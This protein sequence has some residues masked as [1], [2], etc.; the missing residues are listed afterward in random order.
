MEGE[1]VSRLRSICFRRLALGNGNSRSSSGC[2][3]KRTESLVS[4]ELPSL[5]ILSGSTGIASGK[6]TDLPKPLR[7]ATELALLTKSS[8]GDIIAMDEGG[9]GVRKLNRSR[10]K[11]FSSPCGWAAGFRIFTRGK[12]HHV[13]IGEDG[14]AFVNCPLAETSA[15]KLEFALYPQG[16][17][18]G[19][20]VLCVFQDGL[21]MIEGRRLA[22]FTQ[23]QDVSVYELPFFGA[24][25]LS[26]GA[27][28]GL[29]AYWFVSADSMFLLGGED[30]SGPKAW[31][32]PIP[33]TKN[34]LP[35]E[36]CRS[37]YLDVRFNPFTDKLEFGDDLYVLTDSDIYRF[38]V[39]TLS[40]CDQIDLSRKLVQSSLHWAAS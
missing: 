28:Q 11:N 7:P 15:E 26:G 31:S 16:F 40:D 24:E 3:H 22:I 19:S 12:R 2:L 10:P 9:A 37:Y 4:H 33:T 17:S 8:R 21:M 32:A 29:A 36:T 23:S 27:I 34:L 30:E 1:A 25:I 38:G 6:A 18:S 35:G 20:R 5:Q 14:V 39:H 13:C